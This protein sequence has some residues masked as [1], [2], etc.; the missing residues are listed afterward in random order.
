M[1]HPSDLPAWAA[2]LVAFFLV[3]GSGLTLTGA[4]GLLRLKSFYERMHAPTLGTT[5][6]AGSI[7][8]ASITCFSVLG[9]RPVLHEILITVFVLVTTPVTLMLLARAA[10][11]RDRAETN[12]NVPGFETVDSLG[13]EEGQP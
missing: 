3:V 7:L 6:G 5:W 10:L 11:Y 12:G 9:S 1:T 13:D 2:L 4:I 8:I